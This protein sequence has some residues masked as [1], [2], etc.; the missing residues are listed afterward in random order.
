MDIWESE[1]QT[2]VGYLI[3]THGCVYETVFIENIF[4]RMLSRLPRELLEEL[5]VLL[6]RQYT[7][8]YINDKFEVRINGVPLFVVLNVISVSKAMHD[9]TFLKTST[10]AVRIQIIQDIVAIW[11]HP[12]EIRLPLNEC[13]M[14]SFHRAI[15]LIEGSGATGT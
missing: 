9:I 13:C 12:S 6:R 7:F 4:G 10:L 14:D 15:A 11:N 8:A 1:S 2:I 3:R 5:V